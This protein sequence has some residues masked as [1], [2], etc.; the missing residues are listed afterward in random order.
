MPGCVVGSGSAAEIRSA[1]V[2]RKSGGRSGFALHTG[3][4]VGWRATARGA[5]CALLFC[6]IC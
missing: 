6:H 3:G 1:S 2:D 4:I 5:H